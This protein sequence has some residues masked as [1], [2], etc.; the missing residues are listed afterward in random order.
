MSTPNTKATKNLITAEQAR[1]AFKAILD[2]SPSTAGLTLADALWRGGKGLGLPTNIGQ[3][4]IVV[5]VMPGHGDAVITVKASDG[6]FDYDVITVHPGMNR[7]DAEYWQGAG[8]LAEVEA[9]LETI[10]YG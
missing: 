6:R 2:E 4:R 8:S 9:I 10:A 3:D 1:S 5:N 7:G